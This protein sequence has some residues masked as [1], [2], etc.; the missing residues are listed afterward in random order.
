MQLADADFRRVFTPAAD[1]H[2]QIRFIVKPLRDVIVGDAQRSLWMI[3]GAGAFLLLIACANIANLLLARAAG[4]N[5]ELLF[6]L[7]LAP[8]AAA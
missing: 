3:L 1:P 6:A 8:A 5:R 7:H 2:A 4:R